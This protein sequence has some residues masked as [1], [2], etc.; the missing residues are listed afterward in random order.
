LK[1]YLNWYFRFGKPETPIWAVNNVLLDFFPFFKMEHLRLVNS[2]VIIYKLGAILTLLYAK[3][4][5]FHSHKSD[6]P[7]PPHNKLIVYGVRVVWAILVKWVTS[8]TRN[9]NHLM[10]YTHFIHIIIFALALAVVNYLDIPSPVIVKGIRFSISL[11]I[12]IRNFKIIF[13]TRHSRE[14]KLQIIHSDFIYPILW[15]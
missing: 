6:F 12:F 7:S 10:A 14:L 8:A 15:N 13:I 4:P 5:P 2:W 9:R 11:G 1:W 3:P